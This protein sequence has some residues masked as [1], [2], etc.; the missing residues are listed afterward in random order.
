MC[1]WLLWECA[2]VVIIIIYDI[3]VY[4]QEMLFEWVNDDVCNNRILFAM[5]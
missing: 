4:V 2:Y 5:H 3:K 1:M